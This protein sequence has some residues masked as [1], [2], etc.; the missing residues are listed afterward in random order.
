VSDLRCHCPADRLSLDQG[1]RVHR[2]ARAGLSEF[3]RLRRPMRPIALIHTD[4]ANPSTP[5]RTAIGGRAGLAGK[6]S[7]M[8][9]RGKHHLIHPSNIIRYEIHA[10]TYLQCGPHD[11]G[12]A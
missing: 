4:E 2:S 7:M 10:P 5:D 6:M 3:R 8:L 11:T 9:P 1:R 12:P